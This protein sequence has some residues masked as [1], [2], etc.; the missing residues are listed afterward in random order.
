VRSLAAWL[1]RLEAA[2]AA[3]AAV[4]L[5]AMVATLAAAPLQELLCLGQPLQW[6]TE[7]AEYG[8]LQLGFLG[9]ALALRR[10][11]HPRVGLL[12]DRAPPGIRRALARTADASLLLTGLLF[13]FLG[14]DYVEAA[15]LQGGPLDSI[16]WPKWPFYLC[17]PVGGALFASFSAGR[18]LGIEPRPGPRSEAGDP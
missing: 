6:P 1:D 11:A 4:I 3:V 10:D 17:Y 7:V 5:V 18:L 13:L 14:I 8:L 9:A 2:T 12:V 16:P 15:R